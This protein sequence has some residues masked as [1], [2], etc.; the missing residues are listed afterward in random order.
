MKHNTDLKTL[1]ITEK[2]KHLKAGG[3]LLVTDD[4]NR[5][6]EADLLCV[7]ESVTTE[8]INFMITYAKGLICVPISDSWA[9]SKTLPLMIKENTGSLITAFTITL[10]AKAGITT[11]ISSRD[12]AYTIR[13]LA[14][15]NSSLDDFERP[16]HIFPL[17]A[18]A[19]GLKTRQGH[20]EAAVELMDLCGVSPVAVICETLDEVG[21]PLKGM[22]LQTF[23][24]NHQ[25]PI[26]S[27]KEILDYLLLIK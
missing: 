6:D 22:K 3:F 1:T 10:D 20:T 24:E 25:I 19:N 26:L 16:G 5:E 14:D 13:L 12:R 4:H 15:K 9:K 11:G 23:S 2:I 21:D 17:I 18:N 8:Q 7:G 27:I